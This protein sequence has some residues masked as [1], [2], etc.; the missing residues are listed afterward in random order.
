MRDLKLEV[1]MSNGVHYPFEKQTLDNWAT[2]SRI[3]PQAWRRLVTAVP[4]AGP[5]LQF[6]SWWREDTRGTSPDTSFG[7]SLEG[8]RGGRTQLGIRLSLER[9]LGLLFNNKT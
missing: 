8:S 1:M 3:I 6:L 2:Q 9:Y 5:Q 7:F 4:G